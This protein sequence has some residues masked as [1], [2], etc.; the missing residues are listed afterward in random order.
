VGVELA[1]EQR[2]LRCVSIIGEAV[3]VFQTSLEF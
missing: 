1:L 2:E 3:I